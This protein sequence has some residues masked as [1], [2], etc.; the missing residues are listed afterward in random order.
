LLL[1]FPLATAL[2]IAK[3]IE[4]KEPLPDVVVPVL[5]A[6]EERAL[7]ESP[8]PTVVPPPPS[9]ED[10]SVTSLGLARWLE[11]TRPTGIQVP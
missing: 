5:E 9:N 1:G 4:V 3:D 10:I 11:A 6:I 7:V 8:K 2:P